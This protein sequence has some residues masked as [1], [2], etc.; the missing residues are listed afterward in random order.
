MIN[1]VPMSLDACLVVFTLFFTTLSLLLLFFSLASLALHNQGAS[2]Q[3][4]GPVCSIWGANSSAMYGPRRKNS[5]THA[6]RSMNNNVSLCVWGGGGMLIQPCFSK[7]H[8]KSFYFAIK[9]L[10]VYS[11]CFAFVKSMDGL[12][13]SKYCWFSLDGELDSQLI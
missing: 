6:R 5:G 3:C 9:D 13:R 2:T 1:A 11:A 10:S 12:L 7:L 8:I 4:W